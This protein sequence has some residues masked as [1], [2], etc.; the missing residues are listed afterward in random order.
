MESSTVVA[1]VSVVVTGLAS[2]A[3]AMV[4]VWWQALR[5]FSEAELVDERK[6]L[7]DTVAELEKYSRANGS[8]IEFLQRGRPVAD[9]DVAEQRRQRDLAHDNFLSAYGKICIRFGPHSEIVTSY[10]RVDSCMRE[11][12]EITRSL[13]SDV[14]LIVGDKDLESEF[15]KFE[16]SCA[17]FYERCHATISRSRRLTA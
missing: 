17:E 1:L 6:V 8:V 7:D 5:R 9:P 14:P 3:I 10:Q 2:P 16:S 11:F 4:S 15:E 13:I 12:H